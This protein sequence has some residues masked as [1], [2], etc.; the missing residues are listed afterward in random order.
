MGRSWDFTGN[1]GSHSHLGVSQNRGTPIDRWLV[2]V[3][4]TPNLKWMMTGGSPVSGNPHM[5]HAWYIQLYT[6]G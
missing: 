4:E 5:L 1:V 6:C 2:Y 3:V